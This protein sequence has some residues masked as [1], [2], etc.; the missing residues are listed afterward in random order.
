[1]NKLEENLILKLLDGTIHGPTGSVELSEPSVTERDVR[2]AEFPEY[3]VTEFQA[4]Y[5]KQKVKI[6]ILDEGPESRAPESRYNCL[7]WVVGEKDK[8]V[9]AQVSG[10]GGWTPREA[11]EGTHWQELDNPPVD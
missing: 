10:N 1:M 3:Q 6:Q 5:K 8:R 9:S 2:S 11:I 4:S 7:A